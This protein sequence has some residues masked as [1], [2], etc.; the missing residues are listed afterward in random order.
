MTPDPIDAETTRT[1]PAS[2]ASVRPSIA[3]GAVVHPDARLADGVVV[4]HG[5]VIEADVEVGAGTRLL[6]GSVLHAG[7]RVGQNCRVGPYAVVGGTPM[8]TRFRGEPSTAVLEDDVVVREFA[9]VHRATG[10]GEETRVG[11]GTLVMSY[12]HVSHNTRVG[13]GCVLTTAVQLGGHAQVG[14]H[15]VLGSAALVHQFGRVGAYAML[16]AASAANTDV[17]PF[18][19]ARGDP[20]RHFRLNTVGLKRNGFDAE[21]YRALERALRLLRR[22]DLDTLETMARDNEDARTLLTFVRTSQRGVARFVTS[23]RDGA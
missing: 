12:A 23:G 5:V 2:Q 4:E 7:A 1:A 18:S 20:V 22:R 10:E 8:D 3:S 21:R 16:G 9:T 13:A 15:A 17:L 14:D 11:S 6:V 19:M